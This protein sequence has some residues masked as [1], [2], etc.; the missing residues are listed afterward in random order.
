MDVFAHLFS[1]I[2]NGYEWV[3]GELCHRGDSRGIPTTMKYSDLD[4]EDVYTQKLE[5]DFG[6]GDN[7][8]L[9]KAFRLETQFKRLKRQ[10]IEQNI[11]IC[12]GNG[13]VLLKPEYEYYL[14]AYMGD[15]I[16]V[17]YAYLFN[18]PKDATEDWLLAA[19]EFGEF[20]YERLR[21]RCHGFVYYKDKENPHYRVESLEDCPKDWQKDWGYCE[22]IEKALRNIEVLRGTALSPEEAK[23]KQDMV[24]AIIS[25]IL[26][27]DGKNS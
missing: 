18:I 6:N 22:Q 10:F 2:G 5:D 17:D 26:N 21:S 25:E 19:K 14:G 13:R 23:T 16:C 8:S 3:N 27:K 1:C 15:H 9:F 4:E 12:A 11:D 24:D 7:G 20:W